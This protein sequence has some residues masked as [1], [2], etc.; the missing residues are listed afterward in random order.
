M[1]ILVK[2]VRYSAIILALAMLAGLIFLAFP[3]K[4]RMSQKPNFA[5]LAPTTQVIRS[6]QAHDD[7][8]DLSPAEQMERQ[9]SLFLATTKDLVVPHETTKRTQQGPSSLPKLTKGLSRLSELKGSKQTRATTSNS[10]NNKLLV[11]E[12]E[13]TGN[14]SEAEIKMTADN[15]PAID[16]KDSIQHYS[17]E[18]LAHN[19][20]ATDNPDS[21]LT[22]NIDGQ[23]IK[24][25]DILNASV[26][27]DNIVITLKK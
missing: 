13:K 22:Y 1:T 26:T 20:L 2:W 7:N 5:A 11:S 15:F 9:D 27:V 14:Y 23:R 19:T 6:Q 12:E 10:R 8:E 16:D 25:H 21:I 17:Q 3:M 4:D 24:Q 18:K